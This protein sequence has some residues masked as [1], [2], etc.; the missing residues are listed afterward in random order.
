[1]AN[2]ITKETLRSINDQVYA[3]CCSNLWTFAEAGEIRTKD[4][5]RKIIRPFPI[6]FRHLHELNRLIDENDRV[7]IC[8]SRRMQVSM[9]LLLRML[10][11][12]FFANSG[13]PGSDQVYAGAYSA[14]DEPLMFY[15]MGRIQF[16]YNCLPDWMRARNPMVTNKVDLKIFQNGGSIQGFAMKQEG[17][18]GFG[19]SEYVFDEMAWQR[20]AAT[21]WWGVVPTIGR[22]KLIAAS[23]PNGKAREGKLFHEVWANPDNVEGYKGFARKKLMWYDCPEHDEAWFKMITAGMTKTQIGAKYCCSFS[24][25]DGDLVWNRFDSRIHVSKE[26][27]WPIPGRPMLIGWD[28]GVRKPAMT[29]WQVDANGVWRGYREMIG[30]NEESF[31]KFCRK[32]LEIANGLYERSKFPEI[33]GIAPDAKVRYRTRSLSGARM[34]MD[35]ISRIWDRRR[36]G[37]E[38]LSEFLEGDTYQTRMLMGYPHCGTR[39]KETP[40]MKV[41]RKMWWLKDGEPG[42]ILDPSMENF[43]DGCSSG[44]VYDKESEQ[45]LENEYTDAQDT[46]QMIASAY[47][48]EILGEQQD[49]PETRRRVTTG[50][51]P[52]Y[53]P[54]YRRWGNTG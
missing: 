9:L 7:I 50:G 25:Y 26:T 11:S 15:Q 34:D 36:V 40:R 17:A 49:D 32:G 27:L 2:I 38:P 54:N 4:E 23:T 51:S 31:A 10:R 24:S 28:F 6:N 16:M 37:R 3:A 20:Y 30:R 47:A 5:E 19:F 29:L 13:L 8:K 43:I 21:C 48:R 45:P 46:L 14:I 33:H 44:Y 1:M 35:E 42:I 39:D 52:G 18:Q 53:L 12:A 41:V 22:G